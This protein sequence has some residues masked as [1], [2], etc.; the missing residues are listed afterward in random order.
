[1]SYFFMIFRVK[2]LEVVCNPFPDEDSKCVLVFS[3]S[4]DGDLR[5]WSFNRDNVSRAHLPLITIIVGMLC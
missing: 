5:A 2:A 3:V 4:S 1:M